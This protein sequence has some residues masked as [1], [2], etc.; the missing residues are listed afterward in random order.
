MEAFEPPTCSVSEQSNLMAP[1]QSFCDM[2]THIQT[3]VTVALLP[4]DTS[5]VFFPLQVRFSVEFFPLH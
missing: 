2:A 1:H 5:R 4:Q 3:S